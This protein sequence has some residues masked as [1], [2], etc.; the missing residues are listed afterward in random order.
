MTNRTREQPR[1]GTPGHARARAPLAGR[2]RL[3]WALLIGS[4]VG[5]WCCRPSAGDDG[6][7]L[8]PDRRADGDVEDR[9]AALLAA[10][11]LGTLH[12]LEIPGLLRLARD[13][14]DSSSSG[15]GPPPVPPCRRCPDSA[16][17]PR[18]GGMLWLAPRLL[19]A[20]TPWAIRFGIALVGITFLTLFARLDFWA[21]IFRLMGFPVEKL[22]DCPIA[23]TTLGDFWGRRVDRGSVPGMLGRSSSS[24]WRVG[25]GGSPCSRCSSTAACTTS[26]SASWPDR[27]T[28]AQPCT[29]WWSFWGGTE[30][31][32]PPAACS[33]AIPGWGGRG[34]SPSSSRRS[35]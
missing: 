26:S 29:S 18:R 20:A 28:A 8:R 32:G 7:Q 35:A 13:R 11:G 10:R 25:R 21:M 15:R 33:R 31:G 17:H 4:L 14:R 23:A 24:P 2:F 1:A 16:Q 6:V 3:A 22:F 30:N 34:P 5:F 19:P 9:V 27:V 12:P